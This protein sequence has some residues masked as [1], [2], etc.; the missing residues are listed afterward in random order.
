[1]DLLPVCGPLPQ[2]FFFFSRKALW[3]SCLLMS[4]W[5]PLFPA[6]LQCS[7][8]RDSRCTSMI[9][10]SNSSPACQ[11]LHCLEPHTATPASP[12]QSPASKTQVA[13][14]IPSMR[15]VLLGFC[16]A[17]CLSCKFTSLAAPYSTQQLPVPPD[18]SA[19]SYNPPQLQCTQKPN[20]SCYPRISTAC[21]RER[22]FIWLYKRSMKT[23]ER[24][25]LSFG[26][27]KIEKKKSLVS[28]ESAD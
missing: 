27:Q 1:M 16:I 11:F 8:Q 14:T 6:Q 23:T 19:P 17:R 9:F 15:D 12:S 5:P 22:P 26:A 18:S 3:P 2:R 4:A 24:G 7:R 28:K 21:S 20:A 13:Q 10:A 25:G